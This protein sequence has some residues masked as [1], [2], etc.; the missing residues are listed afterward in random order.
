M[1][2]GSR[3]TVLR[4]ERGT[5]L[6]EA[7][8]SIVLITVAVL[9]LAGLEVTSMLLNERARE[10]DGALWAAQAKVEELRT[11]GYA[12]VNA[13]SDELMLPDGRRV[14]RSWAV[15]D[16]QPAA[17]LRRVRVTSV[18]ADIVDAEQVQ[19]QFVMSDRS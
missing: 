15:D 18:L 12:G 1:M 19:L 9:Y 8:V 17:N 4:S 3:G 6:V 14:T 16:D 2:T 11:L 10:A 7:L 5:S 13:G